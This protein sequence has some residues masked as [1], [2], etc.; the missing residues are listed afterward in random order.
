M[1]YVEHP[2]RQHPILS[3]FGTTTTYTLLAAPTFTPR[4]LRI[5]P[6][7]SI[8]CLPRIWI[9]EDEGKWRSNT[10]G[11]EVSLAMI[12]QLGFDTQS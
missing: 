6:C 12:S 5:R 9:E 3:V 10:G 8:K 1:V 2:C 4:R 7:W 11:S